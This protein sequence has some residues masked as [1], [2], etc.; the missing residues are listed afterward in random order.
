MICQVTFGRTWSHQEI[1][2]QN[3]SQADRRHAHLCAKTTATPGIVVSNGV[4]FSM[5]GGQ[6]SLPGISSAA[7]GATAAR[8]ATKNAVHMTLVNGIAAA[9]GL[10]FRSA[11]LTAQR[12]SLNASLT[13]K[14]INT[15]PINRSNQWP[16]RAKPARTRGWLNSIATRQNHSAVASAR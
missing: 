5:G 12:N 9:A 4:R 2:G 1:G 6:G 13:P 14:P 15:A 7:L 3:G 10:L 11:T 8:E 16:K